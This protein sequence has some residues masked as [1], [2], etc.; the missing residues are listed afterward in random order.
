LSK[1]ICKICNHNSPII[2][3][4]STHLRKHNITSKE[5]YDKYYKTDAEGICKVCQKL[6]RYGGASRGYATYCSQKC[7]SICSD[8]QNN[9]SNSK[10]EL[11]KL[12]PELKYKGQEKR[13]QTYKENPQIRIQTVK[14]YKKIISE[15]PDIITNA[16]KKRSITIRKKFLKIKDE[17]NTSIL[18]YLYLIGSPSKGIVKIGITSN[19]S[20]RLRQVIKSYQDCVLLKF[21]IGPYKDILKL[22]N[23]IHKDFEPYCSVQPKGITGRTEWYDSLIIEEVMKRMISQ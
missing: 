23:T 14:K 18:Y 4:Q 16:Q 2:I 17:Y 12:N 5:Y 10:K 9:S 1:T 19:I 8:W 6:T 15:N 11:Y 21:I 7:S 3:T 22:E 13:K 20:T